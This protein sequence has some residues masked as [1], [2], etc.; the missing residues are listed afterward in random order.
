MPYDGFA[1]EMKK[2]IGAIMLTINCHYEVEEKSLNE[3]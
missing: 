3:I 2:N 1:Q